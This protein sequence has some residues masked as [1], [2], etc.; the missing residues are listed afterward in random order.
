MASLEE[1]KNVNLVKLFAK[2]NEPDPTFKRW[3]ED[4]GLL[5]KQMGCPKCGNNMTLAKGHFV[6]NR[7]ACRNGTKPNVSQF[8][9]WVIKDNIY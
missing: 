1:L 7:R 9:G 3:L 6:C 5:N 2:L 8:S 4:V